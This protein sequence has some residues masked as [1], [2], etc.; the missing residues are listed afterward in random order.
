MVSRR[1]QVA[2]EFFVNCH[3]TNTVCNH[4]DVISAPKGSRDHW[5][6]S[7]NWRDPKPWTLRLKTVPISAIWSVDTRGD[8]CKAK[9]LLSSKLLTLVVHN[10]TWI[11]S[12]ADP[13][14]KM[15][16]DSSQHSNQTN[17]VNCKEKAP[18]VSAQTSPNS[19][20]P[21]RVLH[22]LS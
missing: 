6:C 12:T 8:I 14:S 2:I 18:S 16:P 1:A 15:R 21:P 20:G 5:N 22:L 17:K 3:S 11:V 4:L 10:C 19:P 7:K 9:K 13:T